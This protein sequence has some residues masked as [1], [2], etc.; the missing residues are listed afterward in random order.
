M[1]TMGARR[2]RCARKRSRP[3]QAL[4]LMNS[5]DVD[6]ACVDLAPVYKG[7][8]RVIYHRGRSRLPACPLGP[9]STAE[10]TNA[11][12]VSENDSS[13]LNQLS[14]LLFNLDR[15]C[16]MRNSAKPSEIYPCGRFARRDL[17]IRSAVFFGSRVGGLWRR[18][19][20]S[21]KLSSAARS[22]R[23]P[24]PSF[25]FSCCAGSAIIDT[26]DPKDNKWA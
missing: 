7:K 17:S 9:P 14:W 11:A 16:F 10:K 18:L 26:F 12:R 20:K 3:L 5:P 8:Q 6:K 15:I 24:S 1:W 21:R 13:R 19:A 22:P 2:V 4:F 25:F 23:R